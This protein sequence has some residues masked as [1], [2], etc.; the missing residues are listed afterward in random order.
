[1]FG[2][3]M[4]KK[5]EDVMIVF[6]TVISTVDVILGMSV[7]LGVDGKKNKIIAASSSSLVVGLNLISMWM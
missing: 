3:V 1:M 5:W 6:K 4:L 7:I 2:K